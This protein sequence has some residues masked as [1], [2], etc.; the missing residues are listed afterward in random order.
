MQGGLDASEKAAGAGLASSSE[1]G[2]FRMQGVE[3]GAHVR[4]GGR[5][6]RRF[7]LDAQ[8]DMPARLRIAHAGQAEHLD[9]RDTAA[10][11]RTISGVSNDS[12]VSYTSKACSACGTWLNKWL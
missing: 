5:R 1:G 10:S 9:Q 8:F 11:R 7:A 12:A 6:L 2:V 3:R 4:K